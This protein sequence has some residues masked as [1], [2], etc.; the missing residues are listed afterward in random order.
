VGHETDGSV[1]GTNESRNTRQAGNAERTAESRCVTTDIPCASRDAAPEIWEPY[2][3]LADPRAA[4]KPAYHGD[5][6]LRMFIVSDEVPP[7]FVEW[8]E[9]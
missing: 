9:R 5:R 3:T 4:I 6:V 8:V 7:L 1:K 2:G